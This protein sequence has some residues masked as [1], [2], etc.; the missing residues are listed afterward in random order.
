MSAFNTVV[1]PKAAKGGIK[2]TNCFV[3][4]LSLDPRDL[5]SLDLIFEIRHMLFGFI[6]DAFHYQNED[7]RSTLLHGVELVVV[8]KAFMEE[9]F[10]CVLLE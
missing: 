1:Q 10:V 7:E 2:Q 6:L 4:V 5:K 9:I 8:A 3:H